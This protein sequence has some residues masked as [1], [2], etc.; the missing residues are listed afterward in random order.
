[1]KDHHAHP[2]IYYAHTTFPRF[3]G[4]RKKRGEFDSII[5]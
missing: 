2:E 3:A 1:M 5:P 4:I